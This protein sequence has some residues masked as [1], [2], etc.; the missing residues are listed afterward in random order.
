MRVPNAESARI[1]PQEKKDALIPQFAEGVLTTDFPEHG[2]KAGVEGVVVDFTA[3][4]EA[5]I[6]EFFT[7]EGDTI[8]VVFVEADQLRPIEETVT[9]AR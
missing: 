6:V 9:T 7:P 4:G 8:D 5:Y 1:P 2:L 3:D